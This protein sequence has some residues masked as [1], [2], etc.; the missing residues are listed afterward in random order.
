MAE[1]R[2]VARCMVLAAIMAVTATAIALSLIRD[3][4]RPDTTAADSPSPASASDDAR[5]YL[6]YAGAAA[7]MSYF[8]LT[9]PDDAQN[10]QV[11]QPG[12]H[13]FRFQGVVSFNAPRLEVIEQTCKNVAHKNFDAQ[14]ILQGMDRAMYESFVFPRIE[15]INFSSC[16]QFAGGRKINVLVPRVDSGTTYIILYDMRFP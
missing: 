3:G 16:Y 7:V 11:S 4:Y 15:P 14:P 12:E 6:R 2:R 8:G 13:N 5:S 1:K 10:Q 9:M